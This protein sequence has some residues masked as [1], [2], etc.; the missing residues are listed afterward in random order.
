MVFLGIYSALSKASK[1]E[2][3]FSIGFPFQLTHIDA[4]YKFMNGRTKKIV[5]KGF[6]WMEEMIQYGTRSFFHD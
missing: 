1:Q 3:E 5:I 2:S 4:A 6:Q